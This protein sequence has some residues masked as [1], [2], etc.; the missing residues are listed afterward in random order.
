MTSSGTV[1]SCL[2]SETEIILSPEMPTPEY[3]STI[4]SSAE[5]GVQL[6]PAPDG[7]GVQVDPAPD[8]QGVQL[9]PAPDGGDVPIKKTS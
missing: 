9:D 6:D 3:L 7:Q 4:S 2:A 5:V 1:C 8:G